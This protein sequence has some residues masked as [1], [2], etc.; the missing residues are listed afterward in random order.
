M[1]IE[2]QVGFFGGGAKP[3]CRG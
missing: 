2:P 1:N 3:W